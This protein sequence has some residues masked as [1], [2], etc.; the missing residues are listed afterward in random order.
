LKISHKK[1]L[2]EILRAANVEFCIWHLEQH[3]RMKFFAVLFS[4]VKLIFVR[5]FVQ[6]FKMLSMTATTITDFREKLKEYLDRVL[7]NQEALIISRPKKSNVV[8][9]SQEE[10]ES[11]RETAYLLSS[12]R[13]AVRLQEALQ[14]WE[15]GKTVQK[16][17]SDL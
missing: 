14:Q 12:P 3:F 11:L 10:Y 5:N 7:D 1:L 16:N 2:L 6:L 4:L 13:N 9:I 17:L 8:V 15:Q